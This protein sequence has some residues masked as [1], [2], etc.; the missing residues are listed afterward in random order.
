MY[1]Q[2]L[3]LL[4][5]QDRPHAITC[6][7][8]VFLVVLLKFRSLS[9]TTIMNYFGCNA[10]SQILAAPGCRATVKCE[11]HNYTVQYM[12]GIPYLHST[13]RCTVL[14]TAVPRPL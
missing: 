3:G 4:F 5:S 9:Y 11:R 13:M 7:V 12:Y 8:H 14:E 1:C 10:R 2:D 6:T